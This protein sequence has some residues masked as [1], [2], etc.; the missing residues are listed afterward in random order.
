MLLLE[1]NQLLGGRSNSSCHTI[2]YYF[3]ITVRSA[4]FYSLLI[5]FSLYGKHFCLFLLFHCLPHSNI[6]I[7]IQYLYKTW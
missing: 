5:T 3:T 7:K 1:N 2:I 6:Y 4:V